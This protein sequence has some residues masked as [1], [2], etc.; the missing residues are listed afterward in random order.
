[1]I[2]RIDIGPE[3]ARSDNAWDETCDCLHPAM[4]MEA[5][6]ALHD[7]PAPE[8][9]A[10]TFATIGDPTR[11]RVLL[12]L[13]DRELCVTDLAA[14]TGV[15]RTTISHQLRVLRGRNLVRRRREGK[16]VYYTLDDQHV[17]DLLRLVG[18][19]LAEASPAAADRATA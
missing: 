19:H 15:N 10:D 13:S 3:A 2:S 16:V 6:R 17:T 11:I 12:A 1:M 5:R 14:V 9:I 18:D 8:A 4:V 7:A